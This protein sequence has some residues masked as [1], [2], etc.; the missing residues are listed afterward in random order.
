[1]KVHLWEAY[2][3][4]KISV[5]IKQTLKDKIKENIK[6]DIYKFAAKLKINP[7]RLYEYFIY[8]NFPI[9]LVVLMDL[10]R[11]F[12]IPLFEMERNIILYK[13]MFVPMKNSAKNPKLPLQITPYFTSIVSH[14]YFDGSL[15]NDGKGTYYNQKSEEIMNDFIDKVKTVFGDVQYS[16]RKDHR[17]VLK[18]RIPRIIGE[19]CKQTYNVNSFG[20]FDSRLSKRIFRLPRD[21][22]IAFVLT[23]ILDEG[24]ISYDGNIF[25]GVSNK[26]LCED[27]KKLCNMIGLNTSHI[28][29][30]PIKNHYYFRIM[31]KKK[32]S[33]LI[34]SFGRN[35][36]LISLRYKEER[37]RHYFEVLKHPGL[38]TK[39]GGDKRKVQIL[40]K[41]KEE[42]KT[43]NSLTKELFIPPRT[44]RRHLSVLKN[45][46]EVKRRKK[47]REYVYALATPH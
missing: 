9:P 22:K 19:I 18:C 15:P 6:N 5:D 1:M 36:P 31:S 3:P 24:S 4:K 32:F 20:T 46:R 37:L 10:A 12:K 34:S 11:S 44:I 39:Q 21:H 17:G 27:V 7:T 26:L 16:V 35:Y 14:L 2:N 29:S 47:G 30:K 40:E 13:H 43:I 25:F 33:D 8:Q 45:Q 23:A 38:R 28:G 41:L 42:N